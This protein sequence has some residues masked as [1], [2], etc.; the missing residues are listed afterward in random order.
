MS[1]SKK[2]LLF[3][4]GSASVFGLVWLNRQHRTEVPGLRNWRRTLRQ[5][6]GTEK[7]QQITAEIQQQYTSLVNEICLP[8]NNALR[9]HLKEK[10]LPGLALYRV[11]LQE[12]IGDQPAVLAS[13]ED[14]FRAKTL[15]KSRLL[16]T[17]LRVLPNPFGLLKLVFPRLMKQFPREG[18]DT[19]FIEN[20]PNRI[21]FNMTRCFYLNSLT[22]L[23]A[24]ELTP[25]FCKCDD[26]MAECFP[27]DIRFVRQHTLGRGDNLCDF[28]YC[29]VKKT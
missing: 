8:E 5:R 14:A 21:A 27:R 6:Y 10:I 25:S 12:H 24:P 19:T 17:P 2:I 11:L 28:Q 15:A 29:R 1:L 23:G 22:T 7:E 18:W 4:L 16:F 3:F 20:S 9:W 26:D 13:V